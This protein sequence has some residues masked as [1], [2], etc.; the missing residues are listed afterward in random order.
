MSQSILMMFNRL[1]YSIATMAIC[2]FTSLV[3]AWPVP[4]VSYDKARTRSSGNSVKML[5]GT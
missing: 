4:A 1:T 2:T 3:S 5:A